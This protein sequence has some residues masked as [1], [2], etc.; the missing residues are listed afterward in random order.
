M[1]FSAQLAGFSCFEMFAA[2][3]NSALV[4]VLNLPVVNKSTDTHKLVCNEKISLTDLESIIQSTLLEFSYLKEYVF[5]NSVFCVANHSLFSNSLESEQRY[6]HMFG[7][8]WFCEEQ[9]LGLEPS[10][11]R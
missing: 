7:F 3:K 2:C 10:N 6:W 8:R 11:L 9:G 1:C 5:L 4:L